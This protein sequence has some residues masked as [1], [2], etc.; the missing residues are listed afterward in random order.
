MSSGTVSNLNERPF[1]SIEAWRQ[2]PLEGGCPYVFVDGIYLKRSWGGSCDNVAVLVAIGVNSAGDREVID[3]SEGHA[4]S[5]E[6]RREFF[7]W[8]RGRGLSGVRLVTG[9][10]CAGDARCARGGVPRGPPPALHGAFL[11]QRAGK[12]S[13]DQAKGRGAHVEGD[14]RAGI[15]RGMQQEGRGGGWRVGVDA[16]RGGREDGARRVRRDACLH[17]APV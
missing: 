7:S 5:A 16:A 15:A 17:E 6:P 4:E 2:R 11:P 13:R 12:S 14:P 1:A 9:D 10:K 8:L 3:C